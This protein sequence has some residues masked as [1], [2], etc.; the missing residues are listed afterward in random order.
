MTVAL[1]YN[2]KAEALSHLSHGDDGQQLSSPNAAT[3]PSDSTLDLRKRHKEKDMYAELDTEETVNAVRDAIAE[4]YNI[5]M[6]EANEQAYPKLVTVRPDFVFNIAEGLH[7]VSREAQIPAML[8]MLRIPYLGSDPLTLGICL[9]KAR[10][11]EILSY[12][13]IPTAGFT[14]ISSMGQF[15]DVRLK[16]PAIVKPL[17]EGSSKGIYNS[18]VV[19]N[20]DELANEV[21]I[22]LDT[23]NE[24]ALV[25]DFL[26]GREFTVA[27]LGNGDD[28]QVLPIVEIKFDA[29]PDGVN[30]IYSYEAKWIWDQRDTPLDVFECPA[31]IDDSLTDE[32]S[33]V[34][35]DA[36][37]VLNCRDWS[38]IDVRLDSHGRP[39][40][41][42]INPLP[43][44]L[45]NPEDNSCFPKA[46]RAVGV[47][48]NQ[49]IN[50]VL[51]IAMKRNGITPITKTSEVAI[52]TQ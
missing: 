4:R 33:M 50:A 36:Y 41:L 10:A 19:R 52:L 51:D 2:L 13:K 48:Y 40:I 12:H 42:E 14:V 47:S 43:G 8:E 37:R 20:P 49:L 5:V 18:C 39:N 7:G 15:E 27:M 9:D 22:I 23:Y 28:V 3:S 44:I 25:E 32:I 16:F 21:K 26:P 29:L 35:R 11:K 1:I 30:P 34:C 17:H 45:P 38:R 46:A 6:I 24:P 31:R